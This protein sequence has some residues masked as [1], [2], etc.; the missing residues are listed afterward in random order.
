ME[1]AISHFKRFH[2][3]RIKL[4]RVIVVDKDLN[5]IRVLEANFPEARILICHFHVIKYLKEMRS[6]PEFGKIS[7]DDASQIDAAVHSMVYA[8]S[9]DKY[10]EAH[11]SMK[12]ICERCGME[13]FL[14][15]FE[16]N[17]HSSTERWVLYLR[18]SLPHF[19]NHTNN[20]LESYFGK[21]KEGVDGSMTMAKCVKAL[22]SFDQYEYRLTRIGQFRNSNYDEEMSTVLRFTTHYVARQIERQYAKGLEKASR[23][24]FEKD[25]NDSSVV[26]V[27][28]LFKEHTL[29]IDDWRCTCE[30][31]ASMSLPCRHAIAFRKHSNAKRYREAVR[32]THLIASE[33]A[34]IEDEAEFETMLQFVLNQWRNVRQKKIAEEKSGDES[35]G[36]THINE[37]QEVDDEDVKI[38]FGISSS[39]DES[40]HS[41]SPKNVSIKLNP[42]ARKV[43]APKKVKKKVVAG[44]RADR[45]WY[46]AA[47][48]GRKKAGDVT[49]QAVLDT[50]DRLQPN[51]SEAQRR[52]SGQVM[53]EGVDTVLL[54]LNF[55]NFHWCCVTVKVSSKR[56]YYYDP[57]NQA[58]YKNAANA[59][60]TH[61][62]I[63]GLQE[64]DVVAQ[65]N[66]IQFDG[67]SCGIYVCWMFI[68]QVL[69]GRHLEINETSLKRR[70]FELFYYLLSGR[71]LPVE[72]ATKDAT[73]TNNDNEDKL[74]AEEA[75][76]KDAVEEDLPPTQ[77]AQ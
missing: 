52:L 50:L 49:L 31:A 34:D 62:K 64:Y 39:E 68:R 74:P 60:T 67:H 57:L 36:S 22:N 65:M 11:D 7:A 46:E 3:T 20:R 77:P 75:A 28:G 42:K 40:N 6:K 9:E 19:G 59:V 56:I 29:H 41:E 21:L 48:E 13:R 63:T 30:F 17:W 47:A 66:P 73:S 32:A 27:Q 33:M 72:A 55:E 1:R 14:N 16:K 10:N 76:D 44:E 54:P 58:A 8:V 23:Y 25:A 4:L 15:Y 43:G 71:L 38:E 24:N 70:R 12:G 45:K 5:E 37:L 69:T 35:Y 18:S 2:P 51:L 61:L 26:K 53:E